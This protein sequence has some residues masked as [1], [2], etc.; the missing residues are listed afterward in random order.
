MLDYI[1]IGKIMRTQYL[2]MIYWRDIITPVLFLGMILHRSCHSKRRKLC[3]S[4]VQSVPS[5]ALRSTGL[6]TP[7]H[8]SRIMQFRV[9]CTYVQ[10]L[11]WAPQLRLCTQEALLSSSTR[12]VCLTHTPNGCSNPEPI[13]QSSRGLLCSSLL[14]AL[15]ARGW[16][17]KGPWFYHGA[18]SPRGLRARDLVIPGIPSWIVRMRVYQTCLISRTSS[19]LDTLEIERKLVTPP[20]RGPRC[21]RFVS[22]GLSRNS[23]PN[24]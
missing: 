13:V 22:E 20:P 14:H 6:A 8:P 12:P 15:P 21:Q 5:G 18:S 17:R 3:L 19:P 4:L 16:A 24:G 2:V 1:V 10:Y 11:A 9:F 23:W 7:G